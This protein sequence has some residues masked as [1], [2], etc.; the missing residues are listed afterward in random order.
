VLE[1]RPFRRV[2]L[3]E[4]DTVLRSGLARFV[5]AR[6]AEVLE[7]GTVAEA[8]ALLSPPPD[9]IIADV[10]L[11]DGS[12]CAVFREAE[13]RG[14]PRP[15]FVAMSGEASAREA[16]EL[17][18]MGVRVYLPKPLSFSD[19]EDAIAVARTAPPPLEPLLADSVGRVGMRQV[20][21]RVGAVML[22]QAIAIAGGSR[23]RAARLLGLSRQA[24]Q[25]R[26]R[27]ANDAAGR[28]DE[29]PPANV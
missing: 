21:E 14:W 25:Q 10:R 15:T 4:D 24:V 5:R 28:S 16:F 22:R 23:S 11:P 17:A 19:L 13:R 8:K 7:A 2:L 1:P 29:R 9:L 6:G 20:S 26:M 27:Q 18:Q 12:A 3:I